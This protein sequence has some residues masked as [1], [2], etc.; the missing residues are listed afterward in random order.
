MGM[1]MC[2]SNQTYNH[3]ESARLFELCQSDITLE[4]VAS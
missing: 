1:E 3:N 2:C 4:L